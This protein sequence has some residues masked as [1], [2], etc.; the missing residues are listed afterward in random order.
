MTYPEQI[1]LRN[2]ADDYRL[3]LPISNRHEITQ[4]K[5]TLDFMNSNAM[6]STRSQLR[7]QVN[8]VTVAQW[9]LSP[10]RPHQL[11]TIDI[12]PQ[13]LVAGYNELRFLTAQHYTEEQCEAAISSELWTEINPI[14]SHLTLRYRLRPPSLSL[15]RLPELFDKKASQTTIR[16]LFPTMDLNSNELEWGGLITQGIGLRLDYAPFHLELGTAETETTD[17]PVQIT[18]SENRDL[19]LIGVRDRLTPFLNTQVLTHI[20][21]PYLGLF[22]AP[23]LLKN[24]GTRQ[25]SSRFVLVVSGRDPQEVKLASKAFSLLN[26]PFPDTQ[27]TVFHGVHLDPPTPY[28]GIPALQPHHTY[29]LKQ[30]GFGTV[31]RTGLHPSPLAFELYFPPDLFA[32]EDAEVVFMLHLAYNAGMRRDSLLEMRINDIF[33]RSIPLPEEHGAH[34]RDYRIRVPLR[35][36]KPGNNRI[37]LHPLLVP[38]VSGECTYLQT[39]NLKVTLY[40]DSRVQLPAAVHYAELPNLALLA[41]SGFPYLGNEGASMGMRLLDH[42][43]GTILAAWHL[44][45]KLARLNRLPLDK[46][47][48]SFSPMSETRNIILIGSHIRTLADKIF[49]HAPINLND[50]WINWRYGVGK[51]LS[52]PESSWWKTWFTHLWPS[53]A[54]PLTRLEPR[55]ATLEQNGGLGNQAM[56]IS[57]PHPTASGHLVTTFIADGNLYPAVQSLTQPELWSQMQGNLI[58]WRADSRHLDWQQ[59]GK[60]FYIGNADLNSKLIFHFARHTWQWLLLALAALLF[61]AWLIHISLKR[62]KRRHHPD[63]DEISP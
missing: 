6:V 43:P 61:F 7:I 18:P 10:D 63:A 25:A 13:L 29:T 34:Y 58:L 30:L 1:R 32:P 31:S 17:G 44:L 60:T 48:L 39:Q 16:L 52:E 45:S 59:V 55:Y 49:Q 51:T 8:G 22:P 3:S 42:R 9:R 19:V 21:G 5:L 62:F 41:R 53:T 47:K 33:E 57:F 35:T 15:A 46:A 24:D 20:T 12:P 50:P 38:A 40:G 54:P 26:F 56:G 27:E 36:F 23:P 37:T 11:N 14:I 4:A 28:Q 2:V